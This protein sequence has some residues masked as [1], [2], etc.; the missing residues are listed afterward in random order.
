MTWSDGEA[1]F[2]DSDIFDDVNVNDTP[3]ATARGGTGAASNAVVEPNVV[4]NHEVADSTATEPPPAA[5]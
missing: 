4:A 3:P 2:D 1:I 5:G